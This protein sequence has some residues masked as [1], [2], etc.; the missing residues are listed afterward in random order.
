M[1]ECP[2]CALESNDDHE[3]CPFCGYEF[4]ELHKSL[5]W[6]AWLFALLMIWP[7]IEILKRL[8]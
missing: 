5:P 4:P 1:R 7:L 3:T 8:I 2:S 6:F